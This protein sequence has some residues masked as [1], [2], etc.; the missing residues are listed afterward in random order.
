MSLLHKLKLASVSLQKGRDSYLDSRGS[1]RSS[2]M[3]LPAVLQPGLLPSEIEYL[4]TSSTTV[5]IVPLTTIDRARFLSGVYGPFR[6]PTRATVPL[7]VAL[8]L[9]KKSKC[10]IVPPQWMQSGESEEIKESSSHRQDRILTA[11][12]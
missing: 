2:S 5:Q 8:H 11:T 3:A 9:K 4:A 12:C 6:P 7:W 10:Y 1:L